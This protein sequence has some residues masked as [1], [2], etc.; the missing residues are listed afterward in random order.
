M[1]NRRILLAKRSKQ[2]SEFNFY[3]EII[4]I[5]MPHKCKEQLNCNFFKLSKRNQNLKKKITEF[6]NYNLEEISGRSC[7]YNSIL[8]TITNKIINAC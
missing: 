3:K 8:H 2:C 1:L 6:G 4:Y 7:K 5:C